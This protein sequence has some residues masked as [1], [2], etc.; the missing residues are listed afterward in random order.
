MANEPLLIA[1]NDHRR[2]LHP[3]CNDCGWRK[4]G[5][6]SWN[7]LTCKCGHSEPPIVLIDAAIA[8]ATGGAS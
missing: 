4:G 1:R 2:P 7:G 6:D 3:Y 5:A 8:K